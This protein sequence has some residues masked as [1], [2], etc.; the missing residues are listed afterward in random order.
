MKNPWKALSTR[1]Q[2]R[3]SVSPVLLVALAGAVLSGYLFVRLQSAERRV[4]E[5]RTWTRSVLDSLARVTETPPPPVGP[6]GRDSV[7]WHWVALGARM[8]ARRI[9]GQLTEARQRRGDLLSSADAA[10]LRESGLTDPGREL[11][12]SLLARQD[13]VP[14]KKADAMVFAPD[15]VVLLQAPYVFA[16]AG[17]GR[18]GGDVLLAYEVRPGPRVRWRKVWWAE[19]EEIER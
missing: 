18:K 16:Y 14:F 15:R 9:Q 12:D 5:A 1:K 17:N 3:T 2:D 11:R 4:E 7:Y 13:L 6:E 8:D 10:L 19:R